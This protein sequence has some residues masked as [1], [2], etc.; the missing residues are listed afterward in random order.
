MLHHLRMIRSS[1]LIL[2][3]ALKLPPIPAFPGKPEQDRE[4]LTQAADAVLL[5]LHEA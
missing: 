1:E 4:G 3:K 2:K 5:H